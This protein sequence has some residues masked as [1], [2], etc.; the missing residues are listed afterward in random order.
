MKYP[1]YPSYKET[2]PVSVRERRRRARA[3]AKNNPTAN[4]G[5]EQKLWPTPTPNVEVRIANE[6]L[7]TST[8]EIRRSYFV[9]SLRQNRPLPL[10]GP[11]E[12]ARQFNEDEAVQ[13]CFEEKRLLRHLL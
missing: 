9:F 8:F 2:A 13:R 6:I 4:L 11:Q 12:L 7:N 1:A 5:F 3:S 10:H